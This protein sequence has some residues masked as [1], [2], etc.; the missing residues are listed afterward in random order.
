MVGCRQLRRTH[1]EGLVSRVDEANE[2]DDELEPA[3]SVDDEEQRQERDAANHVR[4]L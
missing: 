1:R 3:K 4:R 2:V